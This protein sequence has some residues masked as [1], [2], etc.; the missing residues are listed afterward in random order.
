VRNTLSRG[1]RGFPL[2]PSLFFLLM[3]QQENRGVFFRSPPRHPLSFFHRFMAFSAFLPY[4]GVTLKSPPLPPISN[5]GDLF[6][7]ADFPF[8]PLSV[9]RIFAAV[10]D[11]FPSHPSTSKSLSP[12]K[13]NN[14]LELFMDTLSFYKA[15]FSPSILCLS[16]GKLR[17]R[18]KSL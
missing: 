16:F 7:L 8:P 15:L 14:L 5:S 10:L 6:A 9:T 3:S 2:Y 1:K 4:I 12:P 18:G 11:S 13:P 17:K